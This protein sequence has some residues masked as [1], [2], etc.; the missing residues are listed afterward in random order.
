[1][2]DKSFAAAEANWSAFERELY[3]LREGVAATEPY[4][5]GFEVLVQVDHKTNLFTNSLLGNRRVNKRL[6]AGP[7]TWR[8]TGRGWCGSGFG[9]L[10]TY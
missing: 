1:M 4:T 7:W 2:F 6:R 3:G 5:K 9:A 10:T 8:S